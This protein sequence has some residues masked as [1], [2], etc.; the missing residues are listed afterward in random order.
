M[1]H[2]ASLLQKIRGKTQSEVK[3]GENKNIPTQKWYV[4][5]GIVNL[6]NEI[7][8]FRDGM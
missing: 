1:H 4:A 6:I 3:H 5:V 2:S 8:V 7:N